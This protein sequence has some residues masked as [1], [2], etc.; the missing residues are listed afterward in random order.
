MTIPIYNKVT[1]H[2][3]KNTRSGNIWTVD[4]K[5]TESDHR[6]AEP[7]FYATTFGKRETKE[8]YRGF[9]IVRCT[10]T[11]DG[12]PKRMTVVYIFGKSDETGKLGSLCIATNLS[13]AKSARKAIDRV[14]EKKAFVYNEI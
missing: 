2:Q 6:S 1:V 11:F 10:S 3:I 13:D 7:L 5:A 12:K 8:F 14:I 4:E 9:L